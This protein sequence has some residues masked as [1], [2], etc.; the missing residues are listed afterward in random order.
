MSQDMTTPVLL[1]FKRDLRV[2]DHP[3]LAL[4]LAAA[5]GPVVPVVIVEPG[6]W[7]LPDVSGRQ[8]AF[9]AEC[10]ADLR[11]QLAEIGLKLCVRVGQVDTELEALRGETGA[12]RLVSHEETGHAPGPMRATGPLLSGARAQGVVWEELAQSGVVRRLNEARRL[13]C[14]Q[15]Q[16][17][18]A[19]ASRWLTSSK[20]RSERPGC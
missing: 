7:R 15:P 4:A 11:R 3:A 1:W 2:V 18:L 16:R 8:F 6:Y 17:L 19:V 12:Q 20:V 13:G 5:A 14:K 9:F 10:V